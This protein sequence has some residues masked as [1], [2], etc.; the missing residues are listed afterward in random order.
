MKGNQTSICFGCILPVVEK[1]L[2][3]LVDTNF[4]R[5]SSLKKDIKLENKKNEEEIKKKV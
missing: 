4:I 2:A 5:T 3:L 1:Y